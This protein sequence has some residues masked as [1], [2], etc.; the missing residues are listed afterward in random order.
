MV[1][2]SD[3]DRLGDA[4]QTVERTIDMFDRACSRFRDDSELSVCNR[5][6]GH[7]V[8]VSP[9]LIEAVG[10]G[11]RAA[12]L[13]DGDVDPALGNALIALGYDDDWEAVAGRVSAPDRK[14]SFARVPGWRTIRVDPDAG[15]VA[16][17]QGVS[18]D[19]GATAKALAADR[20]AGEASA[21]SGCGVLVS[22]GGDLA[23]AGPAP[24]EGWSVRVTDDHRAPV[25]APGQSITIHSGG[26]ATSSI[27]ARRWRSSSGE[28]VHHLLD[29]ATGQPVQGGW[30]TVSVAASTCLDANIASTAAIVRGQ[31]APSW[32]SSL[33]LPSRL[34]SDDGLALHLAGWPLEGDDLAPV[35]PEAS[36]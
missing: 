20:A 14:L 35:P 10:A 12:S 3:S 1:V 6:G 17:A 4:V 18:L 25:S 7:P 21:A 28:F 2:V 16:L 8:H 5:A 24:E 11:L 26:L 9:L 27:T 36:A 23:T 19:L 31:R 32:L 22:F 34:V 33:G 29:P 30:R 13:T 15:T